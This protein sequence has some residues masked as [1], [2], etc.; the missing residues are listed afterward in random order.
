M[1]YIYKNFSICEISTIRNE[2]EES[3]DVVYL[4]VIVSNINSGD[5]SNFTKV[6]AE[7]NEARTIPYL[8]NPNDYYGAIVQFTID[9][10]DTP[11][12]EAQ[13]EPNQ[14]DANLTIYSV[15]LSYGS[16][17]VTTPITFVAQNSTAVQP[18]PPSAFPNGIQDIS[19]GYY[20]IF[21]YGYFCQLVNTAFATTLAQ[22]IV[23]NP[24]IPIGTEPPFITFSSTTNLFT[25]RLGTLYDQS[26]TGS[27]INVFLNNALYYLY[28]A[29]PS[30]RTAIGAN[31]F[32]KM[33]VLPSTTTTDTSGDILL[34][35]EINSTNLWDQISSICITS[36][37]IPIVRSQTLAPALFYNGGLIPN[38]NNSLT[39]PILLEYSVY[40]SEYN[41]SITYIPTAQYKTFCMNSDPALYN[42]DL[43]FWYRSTVGILRPLSLNSGATMCVKLGFFKK[44]KHSHLKPLM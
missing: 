7:Y 10:T 22:L 32:F 19:T 14:S 38:V 41:R 3:P 17:T 20:N 35:Q 21:S 12:L 1:D 40:N 28:Y 43:K 4:D 36:Q 44:S 15:S 6:F 18:L 13:I 31:T 2:M 29:F 33:I 11:V 39:Q 5:D 34:T 9:N 24:T 26:S 37:T 27:I 16:T 25:M 30:S 8:Y 23:L 42:F